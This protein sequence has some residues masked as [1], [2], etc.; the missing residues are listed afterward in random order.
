MIRAILYAVITIFA[1][2][3]LR[4]VMALITKGMGDLFKEETASQQPPSPATAGARQSVPTA[5][6]LKACR[7]CGTY[8]LTSAAI[9]AEEKG[10]KVY[11]C[12]KACREKHA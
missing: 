7:T 4:M 5:G 8:T 1:L 3:F 2:A 6:E 9:S 12:S 11:F 10:T